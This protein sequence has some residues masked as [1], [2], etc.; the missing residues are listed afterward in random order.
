[1]AYGSE[2]STVDEDSPSWGFRIDFKAVCGLKASVSCGFRA[3]EGPKMPVQ[4]VSVDVED[5]A[6]PKL[7]SKMESWDLLPEGAR[8]S[9]PIPFSCTFRRFN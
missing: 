3:V 9:N 2:E 4:E 1:M 7:R 5:E 8:V 6:R